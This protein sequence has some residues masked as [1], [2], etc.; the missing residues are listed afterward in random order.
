MSVQTSR[1]SRVPIRTQLIIDFGLLFAL[2]AGIL[3]VTWLTLNHLEAQGR[4]IIDNFEPQ[5]SRVSQVE[6]LMI[7]ISLE[8]RH[9][10]LA[11]DDPVELQATLQRI[12]QLRQKKL[13][14]L[15]EIDRNLTTVQSRE[16]FGNIRTSDEVFWRLAQQTV[17][18]IQNGDVTGAFRLLKSDLV[19]ARNRQLEHIEALKNRQ[20]QLM[21]QSLSEAAQTAF[22]VKVALGVVVTVVLIT[23]GVAIVR[24]MRMM[25]AAFERALHVTTRIAG[26]QI[27]GGAQRREGDE[28]GNLFGSIVEMQARLHRVVGRVDEASGNIVQAA[29]SLD[30]TN[31]ELKNAAGSQLEAIQQSVEGTRRMVEAV[32]VSAKA[33]GEINRLVSQASEEATRSGEAVTKVVSEMHQIDEASRR[34][35]EIV[36]VIDGIAFQTNI[37]A[38]NAA[39]EAAR[40]GE[41]GRGF[42]VVAAEVRNLAQRSAQA[43]K[44]VKSLIDNSTQ[45]VRSGT[46]AAGHA[47]DTVQL[48][49]RSVESLSLK[50]RDIATATEQ[51]RETA[52][53]M[54][55]SV[56]QV[57]EM[58]HTHASLVD[59][60]YSTA[61]GLRAQARTLDDAISVFNLESAKPGGSR[62]GR[63]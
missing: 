63:T 54:E 15:N 9:A 56:S 46:D 38:L 16:I 24:L 58:A 12:G 51:Q 1:P 34:I 52:Q 3:A 42:A 50:M 43:A 37:L 30:S 45:R 26:G 31:Q 17:G 21:N 11:A 14:L 8:A 61:T 19:G 57:S 22:R 6:V 36:G 62:R 25:R 55:T 4:R 33:T 5:V 20:R 27:D 35:S 59:R 13:E 2:V 41:Q 53:L 29:E 39:V 7:R 10:M 28:F 47:G 44:E 40:A 32:S 48:V 60:S 49:L 18:L 23:I